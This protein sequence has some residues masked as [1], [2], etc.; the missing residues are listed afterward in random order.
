VLDE[1]LNKE[2]LEITD[3]LSFLLCGVSEEVRFS[4]IIWGLTELIKSSEERLFFL[5]TS[6]NYLN[7]VKEIFNKPQF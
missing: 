1:D 7:R 4:S 5:D 6:I 3:K 2:H